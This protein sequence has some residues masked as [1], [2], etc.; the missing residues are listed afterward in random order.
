MIFDCYLAMTAS[1][2]ESTYA[3]P[4][5]MAWMA[6][7]FSPYNTGISNTPP[8]LPPGSI[9]ILND[10]I[11]IYNH[12]PQ[13]IS[14]QIAQLCDT[15]DASGVLLD[16]QRPFSAK[17]QAVAQSIL[18]K[19]SI[20]VAVTESYAPNLSCPVFL[21]VPPL[22]TTPDQYFSKWKHRDIWL[23]IALESVKIDIYADKTQI[24]F[25][26]KPDNIKCYIE[27]KSCFC[28]YYAEKKEDHIT[29]QLT[30]T[31]DDLS[32][33]I[34]K[35]IHYGVRKIIGLYQEFENL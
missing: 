24:C 34:D 28:H 22:D 1:E 23:E 9:I 18:N 25:I 15:F 2:I 19:L 7:Q 4:E 12:D 20:P 27:D 5:K 14:K 31:A 6:C 3:T 17:Y 10:F 13:L 21:T 11:P 30:R 29:F 8:S 33:L 32:K 26:D 16:F 35:S